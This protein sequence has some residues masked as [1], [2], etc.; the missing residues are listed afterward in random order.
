MVCTAPVK[1]GRHAGCPPT[2]KQRA[3]RCFPEHGLFPRS[4]TLA[5]FVAGSE[6]E[7]LNALL[8]ALCLPLPVVA[9]PLLAGRC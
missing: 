1:T 8:Q 2:S 7:E 5:V 9:S 3:S 4:A 6:R